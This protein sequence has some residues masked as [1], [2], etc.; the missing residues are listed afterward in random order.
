MLQAAARSLRKI[1]IAASRASRIKCWRGPC[2]D[3]GCSSHGTA[4]ALGS[5]ARG[6]PYLP[7]TGL[8]VCVW[9][10]GGGGGIRKQAPRF[11]KMPFGSNPLPTQYHTQYQ[12]VLSTAN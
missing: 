1:G 11:K 8:C 4:S 7:V 12:L 2:V 6:V 3:D 9:G 5:S 10:G